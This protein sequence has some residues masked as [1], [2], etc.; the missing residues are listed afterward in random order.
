MSK[1]L[2]VLLWLVSFASVFGSD[3]HLSS[4]GADVPNEIN[5]YRLPN[6]TIPVSYELSLTPNYNHFKDDVDFDAEVEILIDVKSATS[7]ITLNCNDILIYVV[8]VHEKITEDNI[9]VIEVRSD[10]ENE[11]CNIFLR[12]RL[13]AGVQYVLNIEY[14]VNI[15]VNNMEGFYK[16]TYNDQQGHRE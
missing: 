16:S 2:A 9:D 6:D 14:H 10:I 1:N 5:V 7:T 12:S 11:Q 3:G 15:Q 13:Q 8:Y 4:A